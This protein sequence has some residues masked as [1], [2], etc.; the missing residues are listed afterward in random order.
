MQRKTKIASIVA[1]LTLVTGGLA[2]GAPSAGGSIFACLSASAGTLTKVSSKAPK[3]PKGTSLITWN[4]VGPQGPQGIQGIQG[5]AGAPGA[6]GQS[7]LNGLNGLSGLQGPQGLMGL[8]GLQG[9]QGEKGNTGERG[10]QGEPGAQ[11]PKGDKGETGERGAQGESGPEVYS[12][13]F[14]ESGGEYYKVAF[15]EL[16]FSRYPV[17]KI[18][19][20]WWDLLEPYGS[21]NTYDPVAFN[22]ATYGEQKDVFVYTDTICSQGNYG[23]L[24][25]RDRT[26]PLFDGDFQYD[27]RDYLSPNVSNVAVAMFDSEYTYVA[28]P[29]D[30]PIDAIKSYW[31]GECIQGIPQLK[32]TFKI[33]DLRPIDLPRDLIF[34]SPMELF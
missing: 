22:N 9:L 21:R 34:D 27:E 19:G 15:N 16:S 1:A 30:L 23:Y 33:F 8:Q 24:S 29:S 5:P 2:I 26:G 25:T 18:D 14:L 13:Y 12:G 4:Q 11:G 6:A 32:S 28:S 7:G 31:N 17:V 20:V 10:I 3:C